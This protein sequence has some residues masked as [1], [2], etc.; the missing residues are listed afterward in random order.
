M[1]IIFA[2]CF[3]LVALNV[4]S[5]HV[6][7]VV[8]NDAG[9]AVPFVSVY[10]KGTSTGTTANVD[11]KYSI[12]IKQGEHTL[13][14]RSIGYKI[15]EEHISIKNENVMVDIV[16]QSESYQLKEATV[17]AS[18][19]DLAYSIIRHAQRKRKFYLNEV[20]EF[21]AD[22]YVKSTQRLLE[23]PKKFF[24][25]DVDLGD[26]L[27]TSTKIFY[28][29]E[30]VSKI[31]FRKPA[32]VKEEMISSKVSGSSRGFSFNSGANML[33]NF[34]ENLMEMGRL[35]PRGIVSPVSAT[36]ML[37]YNYH[38]EGTF[39]ENGQTVNKIKVIPKRGYDPVFTGDIYIMDGSWRIHS[40]DLFI[41]KAQQLEFID[42]FRMKQVY[43][44][45][46]KDV[47]MP[48]S[49]TYDYRA[50]A[51]GFVLKG[52]IMGIFSNYNLHPDFGAHFFDNEV[53]KINTDANKKDSMYWTTLRQVPLTLEEQKDYHVKD[54]TSV[55]HESKEYRD[56]MD[57]KNNK[58]IPQQF[59]L[60]GYEY[61]N[62]FKH[63]S[64]G[65][66]SLINDIQFNTVQGWNA[67]MSLHYRK[68]HEGED[69]RSF[70][71]TPALRYGFSNHHLLANISVDKKYNMFHAASWTLKGGTDEV[72]FN[73][74]N[75]IGRLVNTL[76]SLY[77]EKNFLKLYQKKFVSAQHR[78]EIVN[79]IYSD[80]SVEYA[81]R[82]P[83]V[84][85][86]TE[87]FTDVKDRTYSS[88]DPLHIQ[89]DSLHFL[90]NQ[91]LT[92]DVG[93][94]IRINQ[95][96][97]IRPEGKFGMRS[98]YPAFNISYKKGFRDALGSDVDYDF[99]RVSVSDEVAFGLFGRIN[100]NAGYGNFLSK[101]NLEFIDY[102]HF[103]GNRTFVSNFRLR[104][105]KLLD[106]YTFSTSSEY[107]EAH[108]E[109]N[110][111]GF[112]LNKIPLLRKLKL[113]EVIGVHY[114]HTTLLNNYLELSVGLTK[115]NL[116]RI[117]FVTSFSDK[118]RMGT[119][120]LFGINGIIPLD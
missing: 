78:I 41:T 84:N 72:Q 21:K 74:Q 17:N 34:Y 69:Q 62:S 96:Y 36:A 116:L 24:G 31:N 9:Y 53:L 55:V 57:K 85:T 80:V 14:F 13:V 1:K 86:S 5:A 46:E 67:G 111:G 103:N 61:N 63:W 110:M 8:K 38:L 25:Q 83:L 73:P 104:D 59:L 115:L 35:S 114:L 101:K 65:S 87:R 20:S 4:N 19:E 70:N 117:D 105:F 109:W 64:I 118:Q 66:S 18:A 48:L 108:G 29:S 11:G 120:F 79:G 92:L 47:W 107:I 39:M 56:S 40:A 81:D 7:G 44:P 100:Y 50:G 89:T 10:I 58:F 82:L 90:Q 76:Y 113:Q 112:I 43:I 77:G 45:V 16:L 119:G 94:R 93:L 49:A 12:E 102:H 95:R 88:N 32:S 37:Y 60:V 99:I 3:S 6:S 22:V 54:S 23:S 97:I 106:Y 26:V 33:F 2:I 91:S 71:I 75:P 42:T 52:I 28:L 27:D 30:S 98:K 51:F 68:Y 15:H